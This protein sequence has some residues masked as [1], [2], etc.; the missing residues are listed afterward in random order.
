VRSSTKVPVLL[1]QVSDGLFEAS[2]WGYNLIFQDKYIAPSPDHPHFFPTWDSICSKVAAAGGDAMILTDQRCCSRL[3]MYVV[4]N[5]EPWKIPKQPV[6]KSNLQAVG[7]LKE[8]VGRNLN[9]K[10]KYNYYNFGHYPSSC[11]VFY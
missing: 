10:C 4:S 5:V 8:N 6:N 9:A 1:T 11:P 2:V 3:H 7:K